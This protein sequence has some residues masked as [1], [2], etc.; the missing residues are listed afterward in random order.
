MRTFDG[1]WPAPTMGFFYISPTPNI[2]RPDW[3]NLASRISESPRKK[4][5]HFAAEAP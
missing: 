1:E 2:I 3:S 4:I 5:Q